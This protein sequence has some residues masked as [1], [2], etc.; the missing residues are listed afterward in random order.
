[1]NWMID[2]AHGNLYRQAMDYPQLDAARDEWEIER[3]MHLRKA[4]P[5]KPLLAPAKTAT[6]ALVARLRKALALAD[7]RPARPVTPWT[8]F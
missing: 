4:K 5:R 3:T 7:H 1:M 6:L 8:L 2:G